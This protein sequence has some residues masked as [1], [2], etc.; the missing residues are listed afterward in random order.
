MEIAGK[1]LRLNF[2]NER[3]KHLRGNA[4]RYAA[5]DLINGNPFARNDNERK[6]RERRATAVLNL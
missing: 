6:K 2:A 4:K 3:T 1:H 5:A